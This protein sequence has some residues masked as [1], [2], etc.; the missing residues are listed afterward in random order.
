LSGILWDNWGVYA[1]FWASAIAVGLSAS[2]L[3]L[4]RETRIKKNKEGI[5]K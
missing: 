3:I 1:P 4:L 5:Q 2:P